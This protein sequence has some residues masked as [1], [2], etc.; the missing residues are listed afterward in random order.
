MEHTCSKYKIKRKS[1]PLLYKAKSALYVPQILVTQ[2]IVVPQESERICHLNSFLYLCKSSNRETLKPIQATNQFPTSI[3]CSE[4][5]QGRRKSFIDGFF[6]CD[7]WFAHRGFI[8][9]QYRR[10]SCNLM[11]K[12]CQRMSSRRQ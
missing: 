6:T 10:L 1:S 11:I 9:A 12:R 8:I 7:E 3:F 5:F 4:C 2:V